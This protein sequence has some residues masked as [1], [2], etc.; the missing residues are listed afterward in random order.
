M[1]WK[2]DPTG[3]AINLNKNFLDYAGVAEDK[4]DTINVFS[5]ALIHPEDFKRSSEAFKNAM[6]DNKQFEV[7]RRI[8]GFDGNFKWFLTRGTPMFDSKNKIQFWCGSCTDIDKVENFKLQLQTLPEVLPVMLWKINAE[9]DVLF[10]NKKFKEFSGVDPAKTTL[11]LF[12]ADIVHYEDADKSRTVLVQALKKKSDFEVTRRLKGANGSYTWFLTRGAPEY[13]ADGD[14]CGYFG[15]CTDIH[16]SKAVQD[17]LLVLPECYPQMVWK[18]DAKGNVL[19]SNK[20]F[21]QYAGEDKKINVFSEMIVHPEDLRG[22][23][24]AFARATKEKNT[25]EMRRRLKAVDGSYKVHFSKAAPTFNEKGEI[26][27]WYGSDT[28]ME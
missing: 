18:S 11:N 21:T 5:Q 9:G 10:G 6:K 28:V 27:S 20:K 22:N 24:D 3:K 17:E 12:S 13:N 14:V 7:T 25:L 1:I 15:T 16:V 19:F 8:K 2:T 26:E 4:I 23:R